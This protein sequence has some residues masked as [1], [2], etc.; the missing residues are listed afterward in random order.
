[1]LRSFDYF[2]QIINCTSLELRKHDSAK[3]NTII[4]RGIDHKL[5]GAAQN[6]ILQ[7]HLTSVNSKTEQFYLPM[8][9]ERK[10]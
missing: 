4:T 7:F 1:M 2:S 10:G 3:Y 8:T 5:K 9:I 6:G